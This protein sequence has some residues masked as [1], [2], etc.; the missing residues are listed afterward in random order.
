MAGV[1]SIIPGVR[2]RGLLVGQTGCG[3]TTLGKQIIP[4]YSH[5]LALDPKIS[6]GATDESP[7]GHLSGFTLARSPEE[8]VAVAGE[9]DWLQ[10]RPDP[11][12]Q[13]IETW[14]QIYRWVFDR[15]RTFVYTDEVNLVTTYGQ[16][17][18]G[19]KA[20]VTSGRERG[21]GMLHA[22]QRPAGIPRILLTESE[23][24]YVFRLEAKDDRKRLA[25]GEVPPLVVEQP[26]EPF[27]FYY[28]GRNRPLQYLK[29]SWG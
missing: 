16:P 12:H 21:I 3:K 1:R 2:E 29:L 15:K 7:E 14:D 9:A 4:C 19:M 20:C 24:F 13:N 11:E 28:K 23:H 8:L 6:L 5:V 26:A 22:S 17:T 25:E 27:W 10:Y 18:D